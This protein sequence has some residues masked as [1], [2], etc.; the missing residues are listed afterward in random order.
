MSA[1]PSRRSVVF[2][3]LFERNR[4]PWCFETSEYE[5]QKR[6]RT[7][8]ALNGRTHDRILEI[9]CAN[10]VLTAELA[11]VCTQLVAVDV[12]QTALSLAKSRCVGFNNIEF[13]CAEIPDFW[14]RGLFDK[15]VFSEVLYFLDDAEILTVSALAAN[16]LSVHGSCVL[17]NW[18]GAN[19]LPVDG[20]SAVKLFSMAPWILQY[21]EIAESYRID[22]LGLGQRSV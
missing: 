4:D 20:E 12:S 2:D 18:T 8:A 6:L 11:K 16:S 5:A 21:E 15:I 10:G 17:V 3:D 1:E 13:V 7:L 22:I 9:G 14:P 19:T